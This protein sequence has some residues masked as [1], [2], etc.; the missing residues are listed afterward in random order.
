MPSTTSS[1][2]SSVRPSCTVITPSLPTRSMACAM[3]SPMALSPLAEMVATWLIS[4][5]SWMALER[6]WST[7]TTASTAAIMPRRR[8]MG[9]MPAAT[10]LQPS[11]YMAR[12]S[13][14]AEVVPSPAMSLVLVA[15]WRTSWAPMLWKRS[16]SSMDLAT[17]TPSLVILGAPKDWSSRALR[18][19]GPRVTCT[20]S[21]SWFT[22]ASIR[23]R[24]SAPKRTSLAAKARMEPQRVAEAPAGTAR[25]AARASENMVGV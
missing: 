23:A 2:S 14:V 21:A 11:L 22:P 25:E 16:F 6:A 4:S 19:L 18:P 3:R 12:A 13:T 8:S 15:T 24:A 7:S 20:A 17:V 9:F 10:D 5:T 1:S